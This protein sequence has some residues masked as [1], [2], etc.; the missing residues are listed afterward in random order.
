MDVVRDEG[1]QQLGVVPFRP[2][3]RDREGGAQV[4]TL[5]EAGESWSWRGWLSVPRDDILDLS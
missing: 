3:G 2:V 5:I 4:P 1:R